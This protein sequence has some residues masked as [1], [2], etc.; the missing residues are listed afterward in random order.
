MNKELMAIEEEPE[1]KVS[2]GRNLA[3]LAMGAV[4]I[5][6]ITTCMGLYMYVSSGDIYL[7]RSLPGLLPEVSEQEG[8]KE[9]YVFSDYGAV[10]AGVLDEFLKYFGEAEAEVET[11][12]EPFADAPLMDENLIFFTEEGEE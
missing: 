11:F 10:N 2:G 12:R 7:D 4:A 3:I 5:A 9:Q 8:S 6:V 1:K